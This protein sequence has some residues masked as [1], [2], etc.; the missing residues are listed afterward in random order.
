MTRNAE[1]RTRDGVTAGRFRS[2]TLSRAASVGALVLI[3][4]ALEHLVLAPPTD[5][6]GLVPPLLSLVGAVHLALVAVASWRFGRRDGGDRRAE[7]DGPR[8]T[9]IG[10][11]TSES[12][13]RF[14]ARTT[15]IDL[16]VSTRP[17]AE[18]ERRR[19]A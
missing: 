7:S 11:G 15:R 2:T 9:P 16:P 4:A 13:P 10:T 14:G 8:H 5:I 18:D 6:A 1:G 3:A 19:I 12:A 17:R